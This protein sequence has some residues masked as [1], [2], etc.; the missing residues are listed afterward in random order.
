MSADRPRSPFRCLIVSPGLERGGAERQAVLVAL[1]LR[2]QGLDVRVFVQAGPLSLVEDGLTGTLPLDLPGA[3][4][5]IPTQL[6]RLRRAVEAF[7]P[8]AVITFLRGA[9]ARFA[10]VRATSATARR[11]A[12]IAT[13]RGNT[14]LSHL[15]QNPVVFAAHI[16]WH[17]LTERI[18]TPSSFLA[19]NLFA[20]DASIA[21]KVVVVPNVLL[22]FPVD[23][24]RARERVDRLVGGASHRP[25]IGSLGSFQDDRNYSLLAEALP[26]VVKARPTA[27]LLILGRTEGRWYTAASEA[28]RA[29]VAGLGLSDHVTLA[30]EIA[31]GRELLP[32]LDVFALPSKL[33]GS[34]N[35]LAEAMIAGAATASTPVA[36]AEDLIADAGIVSRGWTPT[37][38]ADAVLAALDAAPELR[39]R[40][41]A[42]GRELAAERS[43][44]R[45]G[46]LW[47]SVIEEAVAEARVR[48]PQ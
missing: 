45:V 22:P 10:V 32:G 37:A 38:F 18:V 34:S 35:A 42:R 7:R 23:A 4:G 2:G 17:R 24:A 39:S 41:A 3:S 48:G 1:A 29:R 25:V 14:V 5:G 6:L 11:A 9:T 47:A 28:F 46:A 36:D 21:R 27:H 26:Q 31:N 20:I 15:T 43:S 8:D 19:G 13:A 33:E 16:H 30:G 40:A 12:W 44:A